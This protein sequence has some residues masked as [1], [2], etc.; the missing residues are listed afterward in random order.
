MCGE[1]FRYRCSWANPFDSSCNAD[2]RPYN[3]SSVS[4][5]SLY[6]IFK[7]EFDEP[8]SPQGEGTLL[9]TLRDKFKFIGMFIQSYHFFEINTTADIYAHAIQSADAAAAEQINSILTRPKQHKPQANP[10]PPKLRLVK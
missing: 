7:G 4:P 5:N 9:F 2:L 1:D 8:P 6:I 10:K 3:T